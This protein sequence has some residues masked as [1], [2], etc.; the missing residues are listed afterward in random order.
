MELE[1]C[2]FSSQFYDGELSLLPFEVLATESNFLIL[3]P[4]TQL[5]TLIL[6]LR[7]GYVGVLKVYIVQ[8]NDESLIALKPMEEKKCPELHKVEMCGDSSLN[9]RKVSRRFTMVSP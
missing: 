8:E 6:A 1:A 4:L 2:E 7:I 9:G 3:D 5:L